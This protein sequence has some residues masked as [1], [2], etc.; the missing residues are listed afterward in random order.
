MKHIL[1]TNDD[2]VRSEGI[3]ALARAL[4]PLGSVI[5]V[6][7]HIEASAIGHALTLRRP[8]RMDASATASTRWTAR[9]PTA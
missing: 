5:V 8:L 4:A 6:A 3:H 9:R 7:P 1:V 2:G